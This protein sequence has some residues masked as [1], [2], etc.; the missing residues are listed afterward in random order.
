[1]GTAATSASQADSRGGRPYT[2][3]FASEQSSWLFLRIQN[4]HPKSQLRDL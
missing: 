2:V 4:P 1:M 3:N